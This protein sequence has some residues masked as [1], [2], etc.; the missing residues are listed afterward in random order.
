MKNS[1]FLLRSDL[2]LQKNNIDFLNIKKVILLEN[3]RDYGSITKA[4]KASNITYK[5]AWDWVEKMNNLSPTS[6]V[7]KISGGKDGGGTVITDYAKKIISIFTQL[8]T[9]NEKHLNSL[10][11]TI[12]HIE[13]DINKK[14]F[15]FSKINAKISKIS[16]KEE[17]V[18][19][20]LHVEKN[21]EITAFSSKNFIHINSL[22]VGS[23]VSLL[24]ESDS[25]SLSPI[26]KDNI[27]SRNRLE[28]KVLDILIKGDTVIV[29]LSLGNKQTISS[30]ITLK[31]LKDLKIKKDDN[32]LAMFKA[33]NVTILKVQG[34]R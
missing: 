21:L 1:A 26:S 25:V 4:A 5:T 29:S 23:M 33:Y 7:E 3:I 14:T 16:D 10:Q 15:N 19:L 31:S 34:N 27:S 18:E 20:L 22:S 12:A 17:D 30:R 24:I 28:T 32:I 9:L 8:Q 13:D 11:S 6:L 2:S